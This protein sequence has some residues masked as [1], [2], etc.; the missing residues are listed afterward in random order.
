M[1]CPICGSAD[2]GGANS[3]PAVVCDA[4]DERAVTA[5][6]AEPWH[7][8]PPSER[9]E[10][11]DDTIRLP[12]DAGANPVF[13]DGQKCWRRYRFGGWI[14]MVDEHDCDSLNEFYEQHDLR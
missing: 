7:G 1:G 9:P 6:G 13:I 2:G 11:A 14:T 4:C 8:W 5:D 10:T 12:P 3:A